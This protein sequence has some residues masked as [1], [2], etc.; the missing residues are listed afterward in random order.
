MADSSL[1]M[2]RKM[3][4]TGLT[5][6][7]KSTIAP[8][9]ETF[10]KKMSEYLADGVISPWEDDMLQSLAG[11]AERKANEYFKVT[12][13]Y[14]ED[15]TEATSGS[16]TG[17]ES[18]SQDTADEMNGR[19]TAIQ[20]AIEAIRA[21]STTNMLGL[22]GLTTQI[23]PMV[24]STAESNRALS[25]IRNLAIQ[26]NDYLADIASYTKLLITISKNISSV[27]TNTQNI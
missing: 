1:K 26:R 15:D 14:W 25:E 18:M 4:R 20:V 2:V 16:T 19:M 11:E 10:M 22:Q 5:E 9:I 3:I 12:D 23:A 13:K 27:K 17:V 6:Y 21:N 24:V 7:L 8:D